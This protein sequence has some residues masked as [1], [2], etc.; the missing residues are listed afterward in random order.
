LNPCN[1]H[2]TKKAFCREQTRTPEQYFSLSSTYVSKVG[3]AAF[4]P[5]SLTFVVHAPRQ[6]SARPLSV[7]VLFKHSAESSLKAAIRDERT[8]VLSTT[9]K[10]NHKSQRSLDVDL[11]EYNQACREAE[12]SLKT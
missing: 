2:L 3:I 11:M 5:H 12:F 10:T 1:S 8:G 4:L 9:C 6:N 7:Q